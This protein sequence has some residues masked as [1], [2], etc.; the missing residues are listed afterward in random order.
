MIEGGPYSQGRHIPNTDS[1]LSLDNAK[2]DSSLRPHQK[3][4]N[5]NAA[6]S[7]RME[8]FS[9]LSDAMKKYE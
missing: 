7:F 1:K 3:E 5:R 2:A 9:D 4:F 8:G 6:N